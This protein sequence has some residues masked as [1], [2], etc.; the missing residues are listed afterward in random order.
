MPIESMP[1]KPSFDSHHSDDK[2]SSRDDYELGD[3]EDLGVKSGTRNTSELPSEPKLL[4]GCE[5]WIEEVFL[6]AKAN[7]P[8]RKG[9]RCS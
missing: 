1:L 3:E 2:F 7:T 9:R 5:V 4:D 6:N 8:Q